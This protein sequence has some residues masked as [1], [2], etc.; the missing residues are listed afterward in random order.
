MNNSKMEI[1][2]HLVP[3]ND[4]PI[5][6]ACSGGVDSMTLLFLLKAYTKNIHVL[7]VNYQLRGEDSNA[8]EA[9]V[10]NFCREH[11][12]KF[13]SYL[14]SDTELADL[15]K[16]NLQ[17]KARDIR[18]SF[19]NQVLSQYNIEKLYLA[20]HFNDQIETFFIRLFLKKWCDD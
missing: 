19:F 1:P 13:N 18:Y 10:A 9:I 7:H 6:V 14:I 2:K 5:A 11:K 4:Q 16:G 3:Q 12:L 20:H 17:A 15:K 8:D